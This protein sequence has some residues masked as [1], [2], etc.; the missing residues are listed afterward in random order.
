MYDNGQLLA[1]VGDLFIFVAVE[2]RFKR[3]KLQSF[4]YFGFIIDYFI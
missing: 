2:A 3:L 4:R 1:V